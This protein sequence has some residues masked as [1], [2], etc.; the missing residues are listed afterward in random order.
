M[1]AESRFA[2][3]LLAA[4]IL[5]AKPYFDQLGGDLIGFINVDN[6]GFTCRVQCKYRDCRRRSEVQIPIEYTENAFLL[7]LHLVLPD[8]SGQAFLLPD[9]IR[10]RFVTG[11][12]RGKDLLRLTLTPAT[13]VALIDD[14]DLALT[15]E[16]V[17]AIQS[18]TRSSSALAKMY[19]DS[20][21]VIDS[22]GEAMELRE[23]AD[24]LEW[25]L[26]EA[27]IA[28]IQKKSAEGHLATM[29]E[30]VA[31]LESQIKAAEEN[32]KKKWK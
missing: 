30:Y 18:L 9:D 6:M 5:V 16:R 32:A 28:E 3:D 1:I 14:R 13:A 19:E 21:K 31:L 7:C 22:A 2:S 24:K 25:L 27:R 10:E 4:G 15:P 12:M 11:R 17:K 8:R 26:Y 29:Q 20:R 23:R